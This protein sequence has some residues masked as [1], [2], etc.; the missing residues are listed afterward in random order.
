MIGAA[1]RFPGASDL[2]EFWSLLR[3]GADAIGPMPEERWDVA[4]N[5]HPD[6]A[7]PGKMYT[8]EGGFIADIDKFDANF[9]GISPREA[10]RIDPQQRILLE[11]TWDAME[12]AGIVPG[13]LAGSQTGVFVG[14]SFSDYAALQR[15]DPDHVDAYVMSGSAVS[16]TANRISYIFDLHGPSFAVDTA[17]SSSL[18]AVHEAC[19]SLWRGESTVAIVGGVNALLSPSG[20]IGF[21]KAH[22][23]SPT[24]RCHAFDASGDGY[25]R[26]EGGGVVLLKPLE[27][28]IADGN[29]IWAV[30]AGSGVNSDGRT[31]GLA[32]PNPVA[33][34]AL[35]RR[36][37]HD[38]GI[39]PASV[40]YVEAHGTGTSV[41]DPV[42]CAALGHVFGAARLANDPCRIGSVKTNVGHLEP[43]S[44]IA[45]LMKVLLALRHRELPRSLHLSTP[46]PQIPFAELNLAVVT[47]ETKLGSGPLVMG[48]NSF[49][50]GGTNAHII[51]RRADP[52]TASAA[53][54]AALTAETAE[55]QPLLISTANSEALGTLA[56]RYAELLRSSEVPLPALC[57]AAAT[58]RTH[59]VHR[60]AVLGASSGEIEAKLDAFAAGE[61]AAL[62]VA[63]QAPA[64]AARL[65]FVF[66]GNGSQW[67][68]MGG[69]LLADPFVAEWI[70]RVDKA[71]HPHLGWSVKEVLQSSQPEDLYDRTEYAQPALFALQV[72]VLEW[73]RAH[74]VEAE[75]MLGHSV[76]EI[77][78]AYAAGILSLPEACRVIAVRSQA[79][80][81]TAGAGR[82][83]ALGLP[84][85]A[86]L[87]AIE[88][89][90][91]RLTIA[92]I[93]SPNSVTI[94]G[95]ADAI[96]A[97]GDELKDSG[98]FYR[99]LALDYAFHSRAMDP[100]RGELLDRLAELKTQRETHRFISTVTGGDLAG[101]QL[102]AHYWWDNI[103]KP[104][105]FAPAIA[106]LTEDGFN[107]F[108]EIGPHPILDGYLRE[109]LR[110][111]GGVALATLRRREPER[112]ALWT[113]LCR[114]Y[115]T[116]VAID[117]DKLYPE[118]T[119]FVAL[120]AYPW[121][122]ERYWFSDGETD[123]SAPARPKKHPLLGKRQ[124]T[125]EAIWKNRLDPAI[126]PWLADHVV[127]GSTVVPGAAFIEMALAAAA[128]ETGAE[129]IEVEDFEIRRPV[130]IAAG[131]DAAVEASFSVEE[132]DFRL[133]TGE[134]A[135]GAPAVVARALSLAV[136]PG[137]QF[138]PLAAIRKRLVRKIGGK[139]LYRHFEAH[140]L[141]YGAAFQG[142]AEAW[143]GA[144][145]ALGRIEV[146]ESIVGDLGNYYIHPAVLD[147]CLQVTL[148]AVPDD[149]VDTQAALVPSK[150]DRIR[151]HDR[152]RQVT[153]CHMHVTRTGARSIIASFTLF[154]EDGM[155]VAEIDGMRFRRV[156]LAGSAE[157]PAY[158]WRYQLVAN[159]DQSADASDLLN[160]QDLVAAIARDDSESR[161]E[162]R[163]ALDRLAA[164]YAHAGLADAE[165]IYSPPLAKT[166]GGGPST[167]VRVIARLLA[168]VERAG[169]ATRE[170]AGW[171]FTA[172][173]R[174]PVELWR[175]A[176]ARWP[177]HLPSLQLIARCGESLTTVLGHDD[178]S[179]DEDAVRQVGE[180]LEPLYDADPLF[181]GPAEVMAAML[182]RLSQAVPK[183][184][185]LQVME[186]AGGNGGLTGPLLAALPAAQLAY[187]F[188]DPDEGAV[189]RLA[190]RFSGFSALSCTVLD[191]GR[192]IVE[193]GVAPASQD[194]VI[195]GPAFATTS[196]LG[197]D[198]AAVA[199]LLKPGGLLMLPIPQAGGFLDLVTAAAPEFLFATETDWPRALKDAGFAAPEFAGDLDSLNAIIVARKSSAVAV[200]PAKPVEEQCWVVLTGAQINP[201]V[202]TTRLAALGQRV[203]IV[204]EAAQFK[205]LGL[206][207]FAA[208][209]GDRDCY[210]RL[211]RLLAE[212]GADRLHLAYLRGL[213][214][215]E[216]PDPLTSSVSY[217]LL[218]LVQGAVDATVAS[219][220]KLTIATAGAMGPVGAVA[221]PWQA[222]LWGV[223][224]TVMNERADIGCRMIDLD[225]TTTTDTSMEALCWELLHPD[226]ENEVLL[227]EGGRYAPR[228]AR[229]LTEPTGEPAKAEGGFTLAF[230][231][232]DASD[233]AILNP[234]AIP[235]PDRGE[236]SVRVHAAGVNFRD[237]LQ[238][239]G[240]LP[241]E[242]FEEGFAGPTMGLEFSGE[243][244][245]VGE[246]VD[247]LRPGDE[248]FG[249][250]RK[251]F[252][253]HLV[254]PAFCLFKK[255]P[256]MGVTE[257]ATLPVAAVTVYYSLHHLARLAKGERILIHGAAGGVGLAAVQY[258]QSVGA[259]I[260]ASAGTPEKRALLRRL[261]VQH[262]VDSRTL[263]FADDI[264]S[265][266][267]GEGIDVVL[268]SLAGEAIHKG[269]SILRPYGRFVELGK[270]DF[271]ANSKLGLSPFRHNIQFFGVDVDTLLVDRPVL[272]R[273]LFEELAPLLDSGL[274][275][276]LPHRVYP[277]ARAGEAFRS[278]QQSRHIGKIVI[279]LDGAAAG[280]A[281][282]GTQLKLS[283]DA[284]YL[285]TGGRAGF[286]LATAEWLASRGA[287]HL[288][289]VGRSQTTSS[290]AAAA[291][292]RLRKDGVEA[293][294]FSGDVTNEA[295]LAKIF[296]E[297]RR[298]MPALRGV[299]HAAAVIQDAAL[300]NTTDA[301]FH[302]V[303]RP[304]MAGAWNLH[305]QTI[306]EKLDFFILYSSAI[307][308]F[309]N[310]GQANYAAG[311]MYLEALAAHRRGLG[312]PG[313]AVGWGAISDVGHM[314]RHAALTERVKE[315]LGVR[316]LSPARALDRMVDAL[317]AGT[318]C[319]A[320]A[321]VSWSRLAA[322]PAIARATKYAGVRDLM[323]E[324][325]GETGGTSAEEVRAYLVGLPREEA[326][327]TV[328]QL[329]T[330]HIATV[331]G[332][333]SAKIPVDQPLTDLGMDSLMLVE[334][335]IGLDKQ[336]GIT[337]PTLELMD[338]ATVEKLGRR[339]VDTIGSASASVTTAEASASDLNAIPIAPE[340]AFELTLGR[341]LE[342]ELDRAKERPL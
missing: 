37:Y 322:L 150:A 49:G 296:G 270:R 42:E 3:S 118:K 123:I 97:L 114:C 34:E 279:S 131:G 338:L 104:V 266:T 302:D 306:G 242:A 205:R 46:N 203:V 41:G 252:S 155:R 273:E 108:L 188:T 32:M 265:I 328:Q 147:A 64:N 202:L 160:P 258:A 133:L 229:G 74:G 52:E 244:I 140:G 16:N 210:A 228:L 174:P 286:G 182:R 99:E 282:I 231:Q 201:A 102:S 58:Q 184:R 341:I 264:R 85:A 19:V 10:R 145:E 14:V 259:E 170:G 120:P 217:D 166:N 132:G 78:A 185:L 249:F 162:I 307:T 304:K 260:F 138:E 329:L 239:I 51:L 48:V 127:Q 311:N 137:G 105:Q 194:V 72:A 312:L 95:D 318:D 256:T 68:G 6:P 149:D 27:Q 193:Q 305:R 55:I 319:V 246:D 125:A 60:L 190:A 4:G 7:R 59:H 117:F 206:N 309:G 67:R 154:D 232:G 191:L 73:L 89:Y 66:S 179:H 183:T 80:Q 101:N 218:T 164:A 28:A 316:L 331:V 224:R 276:P 169:F 275:S 234:I 197:R 172:G 1:C 254:A 195:A 281:P 156:A 300:V 267:G 163:A 204:E 157:I 323:T 167:Q 290:D 330:K 272:A 20:F 317:A 153:W 5:F 248:V 198:L 112:E 115:A 90:E 142:V 126:L 176:L 33:Q 175:E 222:T 340:P 109:C 129:A 219:T 269:I 291:L 84:A 18:V 324:K 295:Q 143:A 241:E 135:G 237:V 325:A 262:I 216:P 21:S 30:I 94:A 56:S 81:R 283:A 151:V 180:V 236:V 29:P 207:R 187:V 209:R 271:Y 82:M 308:L 253:S 130:V 213:G 43:A 268:N 100:V 134:A 173:A 70:G 277:I 280:A 285:I 62:T 326:I 122:R 121:Q 214:E 223:G 96:K 189:G 26:S 211:L 230:G 247:R 196:Q 139:D 289:L 13:R 86:A 200:T 38:A 128:M 192:N 165:G 313:L 250:G 215:I 65:V 186:V 333:A 98:T 178:A 339:I 257:A 221:R 22:M 255:P 292:D 61:T 315:R 240:L 24:S 77:A 141:N 251:A 17:C 299:I 243:V 238:R 40:A 294:E 36:V 31:T 335:Q 144:G 293:R 225:P 199:A 83:A 208:P 35:L 158:H 75:A 91:E 278:M 116:G 320:L 93:N 23:L 274:F 342:Q 88:G 336:F 327:A 111:I 110:A 124:S 161:S 25:V 92:G 39:D 113:A 53:Q 284:T 226:L 220:T 168:L 227:H 9:F 332:T 314:A 181:H 57:R 103:R 148:A 63:G 8:R 245:A 177:V 321:E 152:Q 235:R 263:A 71:L 334:L 79:Q 298:D 337:I 288:A 297:I 15:E 303:L 11:L 261:G 2:A 87:A 119:G 233:R 171:R 136:S 287:R 45:G 44:G 76:G 12:N 106:T 159:A 146:P 54:K 310:E 69:T 301:L 47:K 107:T 50:F 212:D